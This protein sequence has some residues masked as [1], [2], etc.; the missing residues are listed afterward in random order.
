MPEGPKAPSHRK[1]PVEP[2]AARVENVSAVAEVAYD[3]AAERAEGIQLSERLTAAEIPSHRVFE[4]YRT[5]IEQAVRAEVFPQQLD[6][7]I[8][9]FLR[10]RFDGFMDTLDERAFRLMTLIPSVR[11]TALLRAFLIPA[12]T[13]IMANGRMNLS[14]NILPL[15]L[16]SAFARWNLFRLLSSKPFY[17]MLSVGAWLRSEQE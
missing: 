13:P 16:W 1:D 17:R 7:T 11:S 12:L 4:R 2:E 10:R 6:K 3:S 8:A 5:D 9:G 15:S 14:N